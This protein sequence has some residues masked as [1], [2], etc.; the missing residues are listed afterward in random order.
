MRAEKKSAAG[1]TFLTVYNHA[2]AR[3]EGMFRCRQFFNFV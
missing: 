3:V 1:G 2:Q